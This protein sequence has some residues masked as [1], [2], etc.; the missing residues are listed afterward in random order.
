MMV[1]S[2]LYPTSSQPPT[3]GY[4]SHS[5][6]LS[7]LKDLLFPGPLGLVLSALGASSVQPLGL[8]MS[9]MGGDQ[10]TL[11]VWEGRGVK[12]GEREDETKDFF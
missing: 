4:N 7:S 3:P 5:L 6:C 9:H 11:F 12:E 10:E 8:N 2:V 1:V